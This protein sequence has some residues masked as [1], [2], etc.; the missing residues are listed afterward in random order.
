MQ[1]NL[2]HKLDSLDLK[3]RLNGN[4]LFLH[5]FNGFSTNSTKTSFIIHIVHA[6]LTTIFI[7]IMSNLKLILFEIRFPEII[8]RLKFLILMNFRHVL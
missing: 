3:E 5:K 6:L 1:T 8:K 4:A 7:L 2:K